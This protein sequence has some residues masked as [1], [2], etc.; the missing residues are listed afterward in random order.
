MSNSNAL[1]IAKLTGAL[2]ISLAALGSTV[3]VHAQSGYAPGVHRHATHQQH[4]AVSRA[5]R[6]AFGMAGQN[7]G[8]VDPN[9]P[10]ATGGGS[11]GYN[12]KLLEY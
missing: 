3:P 7:G 11:L 1:T 8:F 4:R 12:R 2:A 5:G 9:S 6:E 10:A